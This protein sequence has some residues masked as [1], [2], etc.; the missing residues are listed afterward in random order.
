MLVATAS[1]G[2]DRQSSVVRAAEDGTEARGE[3]GGAPGSLLEK[4]F[5]HAASEAAESVE[6]LQSVLDQGADPKAL[7]QDGETALHLACI[8]GKAGKIRALLQSGAD[9]NARAS[10]LES[11]LHMTS[12]TWCCYGGY[13]AAVKELLRADD[14]DVNLVVLQE[15][16]AYITAL[17]IAEKIGD[18]G[19][20]AAKLLKDAGAMTYAQLM[21]KYA[22]A[23]IPGLPS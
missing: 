13:T 12:L 10:K 15:D 2:G 17:D 4:L 5:E 1:H 8:W 20:G 6:R 22:P 18:R 21:N 7:T 3:G 9:P 14:I 23:P 11:Q 16:G 19:A